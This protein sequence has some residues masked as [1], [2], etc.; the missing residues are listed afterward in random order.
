MDICFA[1]AVGSV[2]LLR[3]PS[4]V[5]LSWQHSVEHVELQES[6]RAGDDGLVLETASTQ[7]FGAGIDLPDDAMRVGRRWTFRP[8]LPPQRSVQFANSRFA[9]GY[10]VCWS[11][12]CAKLADWAGADRPVTMTVCR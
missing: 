4:P 1:F 12:G 6:W 7:G 5:V 11:A 2:L 10:Q 9:A 3:V 8:A